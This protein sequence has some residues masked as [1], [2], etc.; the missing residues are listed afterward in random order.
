MALVPCPLCGADK[1]YTLSGGSTYRWW[2]VTCADCGREVDEC[3][4]DDR[5]RLG[6]ILPDRCESADEVWN[7]AGAYAD[8]LRA[9][10]AKLQEPVP[11]GCTPT[12]A[13]VLRAANHSLAQEVHELKA[14]LLSIH[15]AGDCLL[16]EPVAWFCAPHGTLK[17][18]PLF[19]V[20]GPQTLDWA[21]ACYTEDQIRAAVAA[22]RERIAHA[23][24]DCM[25][26]V[27]AHG[28]VDVGASIRAGRLVDWA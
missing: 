4:S 21:V 2:R 26:D 7:E 6:E 18:N 27:E 9:D 14:R 12:D 24:T 20:T 17:P 23:W 13:A 28:L 5:T 10:V 19:R 11:E 22:E 25:A 8:R 1:G 3:R 16:P 15:T